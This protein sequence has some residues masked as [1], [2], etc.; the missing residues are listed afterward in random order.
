MSVYQGPVRSCS[1]AATTFERMAGSPVRAAT[2]APAKTKR[3][4]L[5]S[6]LP[7]P[8]EPQEALASGTP[9]VASDV[10]GIRDVIVP[11]VG[12]RVPAAEPAALAAALE[13]MLSMS[14]ASWQQMSLAARARAVDVYDWD[15]I[16]VRFVAIYEH[17]I[18]SNK[19]RQKRP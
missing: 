15:K 11:E 10:D 17:M 3:A 13:Q 8:G 19:V 16:A 2:S 18:A 12:Q 14:A 7:G 6:W 4:C 9:V 5:E 1:R